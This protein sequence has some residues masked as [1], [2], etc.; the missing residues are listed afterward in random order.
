MDTMTVPAVKG[1]KMAKYP[2][3]DDEQVKVGRE[4]VKS[5]RIVCAYRGEGMAEYLT[6]L[7]A[8][9]LD[10]DLTEEQAKAVKPK[11][12]GDSPL[13]GQ[14]SFLPGTKRKGGGK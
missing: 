3:R 8:P 1:R 11:R 12:N 6:R 14:T 2:P 13:P 9:L 5:A 7:I 10:R 4:V